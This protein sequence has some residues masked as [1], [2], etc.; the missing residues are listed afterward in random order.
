MEV[1]TMGKSKDRGG[2]EKKKPKKSKKDKKNITPPSP[3]K[4]ESQ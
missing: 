4:T 1:C 2:R 3:I